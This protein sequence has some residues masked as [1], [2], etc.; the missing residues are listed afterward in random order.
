MAFSSGT[1][2]GPHVYEL[3][4]GGMFYDILQILPRGIYEALMHVYCIL[5]PS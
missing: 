5:D 2:S 1:D 4:T 3:G